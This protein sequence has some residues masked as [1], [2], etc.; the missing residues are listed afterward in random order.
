MAA[1]R[2][3]LSHANVL[4]QM[5]IMHGKG[6]L[7]RDESERSHV[8][9]AAQSQ[10]AT[11]GGLLKDL[12]RKAFAGSG[13]ALVLAALREGHVSKRD[14][15]EIEALRGKQGRA[16]R[17]QAVS[18]L[19]LGGA[20]A[21]GSLA[22]VSLASLGHPLRHGRAAVADPARDAGAALRCAAPGCCCAWRCSPPMWRMPIARCRRRGRTPR[23]RSGPERGAVVRHGL[24]GR[25]GA[26]RLAR[27]GR[28]GALLAP[29]SPGRTR[30]AR[31]A[32]LARRM[33]LRREGLRLVRGFARR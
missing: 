11:Q 13:K 29:A 17:G 3:D 32:G 24:A 4:R 26:G 16:A 21:L 30:Q 15:A 8:Y 27:L 12:I 7:T 9:A 33:R 28:H 19:L 31:V 1:E 23:R 6:L 20:W 2:E 14:R 22:G 25:R 10:K 18:G 5:Q